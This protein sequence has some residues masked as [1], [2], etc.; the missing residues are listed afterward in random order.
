MRTGFRGLFC[1]VIFVAAMCG[2]AGAQDRSA[3]G[4]GK[5]VMVDAWFNSQQRKQADGR[6][7][8]FHYKWDDTTNS[9]FSML[10]DT[11][12]SYGAKLETLYSAPTTDKLR[13]A[14]VYIVV[15]PDTPE[16]NPNLN[17][18]EKRD[19]DQIAKWVR[20]GGVL[21]IMANDPPNTNIDGLNVIA[22]PYGIRFNNELTHHV[23]GDDI[24]KGRIPAAAGGVFT[25]A[26]TLYMKDTCTIALSAP[27]VPML[28]DKDQVVMAAARYGKGTVF[29]VVDPWL[30]NEY[31][32]GSHL[33]AEYDNAAAMDEWA[34]W[35]LKQAK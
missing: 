12:K 16:K 28:S 1:L 13:F 21:V 23:V 18:I 32:S 9:G 34:Q 20:G 17:P 8:Y 25:T 2:A 5:T 4:T 6:M 29:A 7:E 24:A 19:S 3:L 33:P 11:F 22:R 27:A 31:V 30:Y 10:G 26:H 14:Q 35:V 15:S